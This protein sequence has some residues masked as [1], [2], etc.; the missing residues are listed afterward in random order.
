MKCYNDAYIP[1]LELYE[2]YLEIYES[3]VKYPPWQIRCGNY[4]V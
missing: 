4:Y 2:S 1:Y 3:Y